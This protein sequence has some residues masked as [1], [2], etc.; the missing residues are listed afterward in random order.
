MAL[1]WCA[2]SQPPIPYFEVSA[3][4]NVNEPFEAIVSDLVAAM[5]NAAG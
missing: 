2:A 1:T 3:K 5:D 4:E